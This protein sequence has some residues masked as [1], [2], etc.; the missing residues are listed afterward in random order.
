VRNNATFGVLLLTL[1]QAGYAWRFVPEAGGSFTD[2]GSG[3]CH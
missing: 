2:S 3:S 1:R